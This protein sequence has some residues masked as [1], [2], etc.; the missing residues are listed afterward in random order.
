MSCLPHHATSHV[1]D[2]A[3]IKT[4]DMPRQYLEVQHFYL[5]QKLRRNGLHINLL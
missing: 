3:V 1:K 4:E 5:L 2:V